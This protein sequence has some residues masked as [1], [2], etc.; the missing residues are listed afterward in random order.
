LR[1]EGGDRNGGT[2]HSPAKA[3]SEIFTPEQILSGTMYSQKKTFDRYFR[4]KALDAKLVYQQAQNLRKSNGSK[5]F[6]IC[7]RGAMK[8]PGLN[9]QQCIDNLEK[10]VRN[11]QQVI[12]TIDNDKPTAQELLGKLKAR[13]KTELRTLRSVRGQ[14]QMSEIEEAF[15]LPA[16]E[17]AYLDGIASIRVNSMPNQR[18]KEILHEADDNIYGWLNRLKKD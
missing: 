4:R 13:F 17:D 6:L 7:K 8:N 18:W 5:K 14:E 11:I 3:F 2:L 1:I 10:Y 12:E 9:K 16:L 15:Y